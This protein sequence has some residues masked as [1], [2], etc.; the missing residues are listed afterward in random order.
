MNKAYFYL[1]M[2]LLI[3]PAYEIVNAGKKVIYA[4]FSLVECV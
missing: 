1:I 2:K 3:V 4:Q